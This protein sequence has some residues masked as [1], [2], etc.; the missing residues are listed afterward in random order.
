[1]KK[2]IIGLALLALF[3]AS[4]CDRIYGFLHKPGGEERQVLGDYAFN[5]FSPKVEELQK[6]LKALGYNIG[7]TDGKFG[8]G[9]REAVAQFQSD[10]ELTVT[11]FVDKVTWA[12]LQSYA[13]SPLIHNGQINLKN[14][15]LALRKA[16]YDP[17]KI[18]GMTGKQTHEAVK[19]F[20]QALG[21]TPDGHVGLKTM[22]ALM[23]YL[24]QPA[25]ATVPSATGAPASGIKS[26]K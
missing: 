6:L 3:T 9:T 2:Y 11:R 20:Q 5:V 23:N 17:G 21:L 8:A 7:R 24:P 1:M 15:Q 16:G 26:R 22:K 10:E 12:R 4:G 18:D 19:A 13:Q 14:V 25:V